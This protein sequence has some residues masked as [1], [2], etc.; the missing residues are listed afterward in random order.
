[1]NNQQHPQ[2]TLNISQEQKK[3]HFVENDFLI[4]SNKQFSD[5][6]FSSFIEKHK[7]MCYLKFKNTKIVCYWI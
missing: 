6:I 5:S 2:S 7:K 4:F 3:E 1:M